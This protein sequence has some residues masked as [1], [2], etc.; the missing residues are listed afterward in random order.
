MVWGGGVVTGIEWRLIFEVLGVQGMGT[1]GD[2]YTVIRDS[3]GT[4][5]ETSKIPLGVEGISCQAVSFK[6]F[7]DSKSFNLQLGE[8]VSHFIHK[9]TW[10]NQNTRCS[11]DNKLNIS[12][13]SIHFYS[14][15]HRCNSGSRT[16]TRV[17][18]YFQD[19]RATGF[20]EFQILVLPD[21]VLWFENLCSWVLTKW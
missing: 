17:L 21:Y 5:A 11:L 15:S 19:I 10:Q 6:V 2:Y 13:N 14:Y 16:S 8:W 20:C 1:D 12:S 3:R 9:I 7:L 4:A 18:T